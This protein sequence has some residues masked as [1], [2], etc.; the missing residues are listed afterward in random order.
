MMLIFNFLFIFIFS[1]IFN[2]SALTFIK[3]GLIGQ[4]LKDK[5]ANLLETKI[6]LFYTVPFFISLFILI[7]LNN[8][9]IYLDN[10]DVVVTAV[11]DNGRFVFS[12]DTFNLIFN[13]LGSAGVFSAGARIAAGLVAKHPMHLLPKTGII[14]G[15][16]AGF[17][18]TFKVISNTFSTPTSTSGN[19]SIETGQITVKLEGLNIY[20][21]NTNS[22]IAEHL[23]ILDKYFGT[24]KI[25]NSNLNIKEFH[26]KLEINA[27]QEQTTNVIEELNKNIPNWKD[28]FINS[29][30]ENGDLDNS[31]RLFLIETLTNNLILQFII[32]YLMIML[33][34]IFTCKLIIE[35]EIQFNI[36]KK[37]PL[38]NYIY[39]ILNKY[40]YIWR[41]S[42]NIWIYLIVFCIIIFTFGSTYSIYQTISFLK[43]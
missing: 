7:C 5:L 10:K 27:N 9:V 15:V 12:G 38:G 13:S 22:N 36:I 4:L 41:T 34:I 19:S 21:P 1:I 43:N 23:N 17:T 14:G 25:N 40:I 2:F 28:G 33:I 42:A 3:A 37:F 24:N 26:N 6:Y 32:L 20:K 18:L 8:S 30:I 39:N 35:K 16:A 29:P 11:V 31:I